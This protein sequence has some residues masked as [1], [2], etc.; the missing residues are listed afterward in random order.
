MRNYFTNI[1]HYQ[2]RRGNR[3]PLVY[4]GADNTTFFGC[5]ATKK[6]WN[7]PDDAFYIPP[8]STPDDEY[9][10]LNTQLSELQS[11]CLSTDVYLSE[12]EV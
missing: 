8:N 1:P 10:V 12:G 4:L 11:V 7:L 6:K 5:P 3:T 2:F 9:N